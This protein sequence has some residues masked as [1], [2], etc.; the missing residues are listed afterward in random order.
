MVEAFP[1]L[2]ISVLSQEILSGTEQA[3]VPW[4]RLDLFYARH[5]A[6]RRQKKDLGGKTDPSIAPPRS[7]KLTARNSANLGQGDSRRAVEKLAT[8]AGV[9]SMTDDFTID[10]SLVNE[11]LPIP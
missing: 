10:D 6:T 2:P 4:K 11:L 3:D 1:T 5:S 9:A 8:W 7:K